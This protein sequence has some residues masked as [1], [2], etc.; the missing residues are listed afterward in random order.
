MKI[1]LLA[2]LIAAIRVAVQLIDGKHFSCKSP[3]AAG[4]VITLLKKLGDDT[5]IPAAVANEGET[6]YTVQYGDTLGA[7]AK[8]H[9]GNVMQYKAIYERN[10]D[11]LVNANTI[12]E[13][14]VIVLPAK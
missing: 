6:L 14:Q 11:R 8:A 13:G 5:L 2:A 10:A 4:A 12:Y 7:S 9:Y 3:L 1:H